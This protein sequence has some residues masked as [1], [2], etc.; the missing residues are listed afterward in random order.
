VPWK[1]CPNCQRL[2]YSAA[3]TP[4]RWICPHCEHDLTLIPDITPDRAEIEAEFSKIPGWDEW[5]R[6][7]R[8]PAK[9]TPNSAD[10]GP[11]TPPGHGQ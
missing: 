5:K 2:S 11:G 10:P 3:T 1:R 4:I 6:Y 8:G 7:Y 9:D